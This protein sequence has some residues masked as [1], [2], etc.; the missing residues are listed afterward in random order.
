M[1][2]PKQKLPMQRKHEL[3]EQRKR[4][5]EIVFLASLDPAERDKLATKEERAAAIAMRKLSVMSGRV[6]QTLQCTVTE[7]DRW[8]ADGRLRHLYTRRVDAGW[9]KHTVCRFWH[10]L[11]VERAMS[12]V[13]VSRATDQAERVTRRA[14]PRT[15]KTSYTTVTEFLAI[16]GEKEKTNVA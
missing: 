12:L 13:D 5:L 8:D 11:D 6:R 4:G 16:E 14:K 15:I 1:A 9:G 2:E 3:E 10:V 7:L